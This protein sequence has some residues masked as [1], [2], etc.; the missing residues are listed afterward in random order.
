MFS[1]KKFIVISPF[2]NLYIFIT[3]AGNLGSLY[4]FHLGSLHMTSR[5]KSNLLYSSQIY[6]VGLMI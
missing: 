5:F 2:S 3:T 6:N 1:Y 4:L